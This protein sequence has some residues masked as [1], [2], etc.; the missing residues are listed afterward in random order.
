[1]PPK[2]CGGIPQ[3]KGKA[4]KGVRQAKTG[5]KANKPKTAEEKA[6]EK[7]EEEK[8]KKEKKAMADSVDKSFGAK[9]RNKSK[10]VQA[11]FGGKKGMKS[12]IAAREEAARQAA[13]DRKKAAKAAEEEMS[14]LFGKIDEKKRGR[15]MVMFNGK[16]M[17]R[18]EIAAAKETAE[19]EKAAQAAKQ[20]AYDAMSPEEKCEHHRALLDSDTCTPVTAESFAVW[21]AAKDERVLAQ[22]AATAAAASKNR[23]GK[24]K[25]RKKVGGGEEVSELSGKDLFQLDAT[26]FQDDDAAVAKDEEFEYEGPEDGGVDDMVGSGFQTAQFSDDEDEDEGEAGGAAA[27]PLAPGAGADPSLYAGGDDLDDLDDMAFSDDEEPAKVEVDASV[28]KEEEL[29]GLDDLDE[30]AFSDDE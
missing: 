26:I 30:M 19:A 16:K 22:K 12:D 8:R 20:A 11:E 6:K 27:P 25:K 7:K 17:T 13:L 15:T 10:Q 18:N 5:S 14:A 9:N 29:D 4:K 2:S 3:A 1:M 23:D 28:F 24:D 21:R